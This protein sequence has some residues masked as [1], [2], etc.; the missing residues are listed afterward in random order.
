[1]LKNFKRMLLIT[2]L[3]GFFRFSNWFF[4]VFPLNWLK[5]LRTQFGLHQKRY[6]PVC[7]EPKESIPSALIWYGNICGINFGIG[8]ILFVSKSPGSFSLEYSPLEFHYFVSECVGLNW[9][10]VLIGTSSE[11]AEGVRLVWNCRSDSNGFI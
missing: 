8:D 5:N 3:Y 2:S 9:N 11:M 7:F 4:R 6:E 10:M 1:M